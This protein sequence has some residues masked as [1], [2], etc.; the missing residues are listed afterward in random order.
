[1]PLQSADRFPLLLAA[2][3]LH[4]VVQRQQ[5]ADLVMPSKLTNIMAAG[6]PFIATATPETE[7][8]RVTPESRAGLLVPPEEARLPGPGGS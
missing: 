2:A 4:L 5:A 3:D 6:R 7:L 1:M 8:A